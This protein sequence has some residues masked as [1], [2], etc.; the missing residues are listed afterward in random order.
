MSTV[1]LALDGMTCA[2]CAARIEK[3]LNKIDGVRA[4]VNFATEQAA[5]DFDEGVT[6][7]DLVAAVQATGYTATVDRAD[8]NHD[9]E[10]R[11]RLIVSAA[12]SVPVLHRLRGWA[13][14]RAALDGVAAAVVGTLAVAAA[15]LAGTAI[16]DGLTAVLAAGSFAALLATRVNPAALIALG[17]MAGI[18]GSWLAG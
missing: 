1:T 2:S 9:D 7:D 18:A 5:V 8:R 16:V 12:L 6:T 17:A 14:A 15:Q 11:R 4:T 13:R 3:R 10:Y